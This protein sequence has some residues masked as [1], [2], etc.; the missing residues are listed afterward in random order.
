MSKDSKDQ[1]K[2]LK[3][4]KPSILQPPDTVLNENIINN[5]KKCAVPISI[6]DNKNSHLEEWKNVEL[7]CTKLTKYCLM[8]SKIR[9]TC[10]SIFQINLSSFTLFLFYKLISL[11]FCSF[12]CYHDNGWLCIGTRCF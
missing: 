2:K 11:F 12:G 7:D 4:L 5:I 8:L 3:I 1:L 6:V 9:L 10:E